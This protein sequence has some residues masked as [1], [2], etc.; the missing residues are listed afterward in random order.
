[1]NKNGFGQNVKDKTLILPNYG[2]QFVEVV[3]EA[4]E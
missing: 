2:R 1:M 3:E 4:M